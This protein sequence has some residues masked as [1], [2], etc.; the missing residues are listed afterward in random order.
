MLQP[1]SFTDFAIRVFA[2]ADALT[3]P[4]KIAPYCL[5]RQVL[6]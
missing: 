6:N 2:R 1:A 5:T 4:T 3:L